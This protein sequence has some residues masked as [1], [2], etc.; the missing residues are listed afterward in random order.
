VGGGLG[1]AVV[2]EAIPSCG[3]QG[4]E[5][6]GWMGKTSDAFGGILPKRL[7]TPFPMSIRGAKPGEDRPDISTCR[8]RRTFLSA[9]DRLMTPFL[10][11][12]AEKAYDP[13]FTGQLE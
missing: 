1:V 12:A 7:M 10:P 9:L 2:G 3:R 11:P 5:E 6:G 13:F 4:V 8:N